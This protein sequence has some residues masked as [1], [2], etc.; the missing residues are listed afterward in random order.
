MDRTGISA[1]LL[2]KPEVD[3]AAVEIPSPEGIDTE[4]YPKKEKFQKAVRGFCTNIRQHRSVLETL[5]TL[6]FHVA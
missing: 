4:Y 5:L 6:N 3:R 1:E 2:T